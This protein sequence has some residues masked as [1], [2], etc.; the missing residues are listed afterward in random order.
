MLREILFLKMEQGLMWTRFR[1]AVMFLTWAVARVGLLGLGASELA[2]GRPLRGWR[3][4]LQE[5]AYWG[6]RAFFFCMGV[7][8]VTVK[9][10]QVRGLRGKRACTNDVCSGRGQKDDSRKEGGGIDSKIPKD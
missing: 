5:V 4:G 1:F 2:S 7:H 9:G 10:V 6:N 3:R 8:W